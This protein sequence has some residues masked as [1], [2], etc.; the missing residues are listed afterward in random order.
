MKLK[1]NNMT[2]LDAYIAAKSIDNAFSDLLGLRITDYKEGYARVE[3]KIEAQHKNY[4]GSVHGGCIYTLA[5]VVTGT[6][7]ATYGYRGT[8]ISG[9]IN[10]LKAA[11][12]SE[13]LIGEARVQRHGKT[14]AVFEA[15]VKNEKDELIATGIFTYFNLGIPL[16][17]EKAAENTEKE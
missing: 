3:M 8:T 4:M 14:I 13:C 5:D 12:N 17:P 15:S 6:A 11:V 2:N 10:Y 16:L 7:M 9:S 1:G